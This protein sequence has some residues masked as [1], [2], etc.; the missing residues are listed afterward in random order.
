MQGMPSPPEQP[1]LESENYQWSSYEKV[2]IKKVNLLDAV[3]VHSKRTTSSSC[4]T[5]EFILLRFLWEL[6]IELAPSVESANSAWSRSQ[7]ALNRPDQS[8]ECEPFVME[9]GWAFPHLN[10]NLFLREIW[11]WPWND[12]DKKFQLTTVIL[13]ARKLALT[14]HLAFTIIYK[15][16]EM[17]NYRTNSDR[18]IV[19]RR[20][21]KNIPNIN[22]YFIFIHNINICSLPAQ[23]ISESVL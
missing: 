3:V 5:W 4:L 18:N 6:L 21:P 19:M 2:W 9:L 7:S 1:T 11:F 20:G 13:R 16:Y 12:L 22:T 23:G 14:I 8:K 17:I 15:W 10:T